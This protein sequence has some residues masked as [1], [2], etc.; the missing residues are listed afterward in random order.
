MNRFTFHFSLRKAGIWIAVLLSTAIVLWNPKD[1]PPKEPKPRILTVRG[2]GT[3]Q[4]FF[5]A[6]KGYNLIMVQLESFQN[7]LINTT[8]ENQ[9]LTPVMNELIAKSVYF[10]YIFQQIGSGN[11]SDAEFMSNTSLYPIGSQAMSAAYGNRK[12]PSLAR[13][14]HK[15]GYAANTFHVN[16]VSFWDRKQ[17]YPALGFDAYY[18]KPYY[19]PKKFNRFGAS[20]EELFRVGINKLSDLNLNH[21][22]FYA[23]FVTVSSHSPYKIPKDRK[24]LKLSWWMTH[25]QLGDYLTAVN[26]ADYALGTFIDNLKK[27]GLWNNSILVV[28][29]DH[30]G[31]NKKKH[32]PGVISKTLGIPYH[33][34]ISTFNVPLVIHFP[35]QDE[36]EVIHQTGGQVDILPTIANIMGISLEDEGFMSFGHDLLNVRH[37]IVGM[38][39]YLPTGSFFNDDILFIPGKKGFE[40]GRATWIRTLEPVEDIAPYKQDY[41]YILQWMKKS[42]KHVKQLPVRTGPKKIT[43]DTGL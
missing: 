29:G 20:D 7:F 36:G 33:K 22:K 27:T 18:D 2:T 15:R 10:P 4:T 43:T 6:G 19:Q 39:Y 16:D 17:M 41:D 35:G 13:L 42:D 32:D 8:I 34:Q 21:K 26:Y 31:L 24:R 38:R 12:V 40:D 9:P 23:Q 11:T 1:R 14:M 5:G 25:K 30:F 37:N 28:Y 3:G